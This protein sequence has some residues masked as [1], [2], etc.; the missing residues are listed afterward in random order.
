M[1]KLNL[2][3]GRFKKEGFINVDVDARTQPEVLHDLN[4]YP[5]PFS[6]AEFGHIE[7]D[8]VLEHLNDPIRTMKELHRILQ[9]EGTLVVR[10]PHFSRGFTNPDHKRGFD[11]TFAYWFDPKMEVWYC[12]APYDLK[13]MRFRWSSQPYLKKKLFSLPTYA[14]SCVAGGLIDFFA[15]LSPLLCSRLWCFW[16]GGFEEMEFVFIKRGGSSPQGRT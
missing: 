14:A 12:G 2:G 16:V 15:N 13:K 9:P 3:C 6:E 10:L 1:K 5:Y 7:A 11:F 8:H 4:A